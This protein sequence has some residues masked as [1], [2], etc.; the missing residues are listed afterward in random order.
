MNIEQQIIKAFHEACDVWE[1]RAN[2]EYEKRFPLRQLRKWQN[3]FYC[4]FL[5]NLFIEVGA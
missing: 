2:K 3:P 4:P 1:K 5:K